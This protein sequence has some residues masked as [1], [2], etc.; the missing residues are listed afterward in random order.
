MWRAYHHMMAPAFCNIT[1][2]FT[3]SEANQYGNLKVLICT[4][5]FC[6]ILVQ[7]DPGKQAKLNI[8]EAVDYD[9]I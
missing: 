6:F 9:L 1:Q 5:T 4:I 2:I 7:T 3:S 8:Y